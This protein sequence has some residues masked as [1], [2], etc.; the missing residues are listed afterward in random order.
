MKKEIL[1]LIS[2]IMLLTSCASKKYKN[3]DYLEDTNNK[4]EKPTLNI[5]VPEIQNS[6]TTKSLFLYMEAIGIKK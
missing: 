6:R 1:L 2:S 4:E 5:F 3:V